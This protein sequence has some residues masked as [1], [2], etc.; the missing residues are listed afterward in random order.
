MQEEESKLAEGTHK[1]AIFQALKEAGSD[2]YT[3][4]QII[5]AVQKIGLKD[6]TGDSRKI[7]GTVSSYSL[8]I[9]RQTG[10]C[11]LIWL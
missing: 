11:K 8:L 10:T 6:Y 1:A 2:G 4:N 9:S 5:E 3:V 7:V